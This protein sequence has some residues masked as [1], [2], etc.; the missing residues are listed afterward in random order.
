MEL[1]HNTL[2]MDETSSWVSDSGR[3]T[4]LETGLFLRS[5]GYMGRPLERVGY[6]SRKGVIPADPSGRVFDQAGAH[7]PGLYVSGWVRRGPSGV[8]GTNKKDASDVAQAMLG[9]HRASS[10]SAEPEFEA[11][12]ARVVRP[13]AI[14]KDDWRYIDQREIALGQPNGRPRRKFLSAAEVAEELAQIRTL[15]RT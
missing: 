8:I 1:G 4:T 3:S 15:E 11:W 9:D 10:I 12:H 14:T 5:V 2:E 6:C 13:S 7:V